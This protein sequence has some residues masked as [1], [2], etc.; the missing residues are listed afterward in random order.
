ML[1]LR[2]IAVTGGLSCGKTTVCQLFQKKGAYI[3]NADAIV[4]QLFSPQSP[5]KKQLIE[6][7]GEEIFQDAQVDT[8]KVA[9]KVFSNKEI[10]AALEALLHPKVIEEIEKQYNQVQKRKEY[11]VFIVEIPLLYEI[12]KAHLFDTIIAVIS[13]PKIAKKRFKEKTKYSAEEFEKRMTH[14]LPTSEKSAR[15]DFTIENNGSYAELESQV[16]SIYQQ[17]TQE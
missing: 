15:A 12:K 9:A 3:V 11:T 14:Q 1:I 6:L 4:H 8:A 16:I 10:L 13:D 2:K 5:I 17:I 7:L